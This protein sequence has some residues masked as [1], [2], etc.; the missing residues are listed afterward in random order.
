LLFEAFSSPSVLAPSRAKLQKAVAG[1]S[2]EK[3]VLS[4]CVRVIQLV[5]ANKG[6]SPTQKNQYLPLGV[7]QSVVVNCSVYLRAGFDTSNIIATHGIS[8][9]VSSRPAENTTIFR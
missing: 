2:T 4:E 6:K 7:A 5:K 1:S 3:L 9:M 8:V